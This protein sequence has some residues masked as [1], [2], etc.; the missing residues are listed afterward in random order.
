M[1]N[2]L[3]KSLFTVAYFGLFRVSKIVAQTATVSG[4]A[5]GSKDIIV[6]E[7]SVAIT[8]RRHK[9]N[10]TG[11]PV[12]IKLLAEADKSICLVRWINAYSQAV[13]H[14]AVF[15]CF[16]CH[17]NSATVTRQQFSG[18]LAKSIAK[19]RYAPGHYRSNSF[20]IEE[21]QTS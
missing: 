19:T 1:Q 9:T 14:I 21:H 12:T 3:F 6:T 13:Q 4:T 7:D 16:F 15:C 17:H 18:V 10:Q 5:I 20:H 8:I 2:Q 11:F